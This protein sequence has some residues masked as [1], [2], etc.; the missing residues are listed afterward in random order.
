MQIINFISRNWKLIT[1]SIS[2]ITAIIGWIG[3]HRAE[4]WNR[5]KVIISNAIEKAELLNGATGE[6]KK[7]YALAMCSKLKIATKKIDE[8]IERQLLLTKNVNVAKYKEKQI[9]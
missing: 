4:V 6:Q 1:T 2:I 8:E 7:A 5:A 9:Y 3:K